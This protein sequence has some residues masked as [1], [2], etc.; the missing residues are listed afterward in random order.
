MSH[1]DKISAMREGGKRLAIVRDALVEFTRPGL[2]FAEI[3][4]EAQRLIKAQGCVPNFA[5]VPGYHWAT[6]LM[7]NDEV[8][9]GIPSDK[10]VVKE[11]DLIKID[12]GLLYEGWNLDTTATT[13]MP[14]VSEKVRQFVETSQKALN[15]AI[16]AATAGNSVH[17]VSR[18]MQKV[19]EGKGYGMVY[20]LTGHGIGRELHEDPAIPCIA[21]RSEKRK[22]LSAGQTIAVEVM[23]TMGRPDLDVDADGWTYRTIDGSWSAMMEETVLVTDNGP[24][25]LTKV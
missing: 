25:I 8:C 18:A 22:I 23:S 1:I 17:E 13:I 3:E 7:K 24:E 20:Q 21:L 6:C 14:G 4:A 15:K 12:V 9:H 2:N 10:K 11:T 16:E 5:L 19:V